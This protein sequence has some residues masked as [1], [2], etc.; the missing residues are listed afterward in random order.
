[1]AL[2]EMLGSICAI[3]AAITGVVVSLAYGLGFWTI[4][5]GIVSFLIGWC[6]GAAPL[7]MIIMRFQSSGYEKSDE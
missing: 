4:L 1:M 5:I 2:P 7:T 6:I 3:I